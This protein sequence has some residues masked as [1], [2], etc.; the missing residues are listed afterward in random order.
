L[1]Y[2][3]DNACGHI[4]V[5]GSAANY[6]TAPA[7][8]AGYYNWSVP[9]GAINFTGQGTNNISL[10]FPD[11]F[12]SGT[13]SVTTSNG[14]NIA[15]TRSFTVRKLLPETP[16]NISITELISCPDRVYQ[17]QM[18]SLPD[19]AQ[20]IQWT[21]PPGATI[22]S[23]Q[24][25][26]SLTVAYPPVSINSKVT[27]TAWSDCGSSALKRLW[28][29]LPACPPGSIAT[30]GD[31]QPK[32]MTEP[33]NNPGD[34][35]SAVLFPN[36]STSEFR[37][38]VTSP[39]NGPVTVSIYDL[40]GRM[41]RKMNVKANETNILGRDWKAGVYILAIEQGGKTKKIKAIKF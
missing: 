33:E 21:V 20:T 1:I 37:F 31:Q 35:I 18:P 22:L 13:V 4:G 23:G 16:Q 14:C 5:T 2:G 25:T 11:N 32:N 10:V 30:N 29:V 17:Y 36:P 15:G 19:F 24:G 40:Q 38:N 26:I 39:F 28:I 7:A 6:T 8:N 9:V 12:S 41:I 3:A 34:E 27:A